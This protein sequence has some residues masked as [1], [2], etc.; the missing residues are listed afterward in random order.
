MSPMG[1]M[2]QRNWRLD[3]RYCTNRVTSLDSH[4]VY[5]VVTADLRI[6]GAGHCLAESM[7]GA[8]DTTVHTSE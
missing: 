7:P 5:S 6:Y 4:T 8:D 3:S 1:R 2:W